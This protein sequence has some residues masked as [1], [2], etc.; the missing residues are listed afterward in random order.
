MKKYN[1][2]WVFGDSWG[3]G[4]E[5]KF[6]QGEVPFANLL[7]RIYD[8]QL[9]NWAI[10]NQSL[11][12]ITRSVAQHAE[13]FE[14]DDLVL[15]V[16]PPD[17][18]WYTEWQTI[19][20]SKQEFFLDKSPE[21]FQYHHQLFIFAIC[22]ILEKKQCQ[23]LLMHNYGDFPLKD[24][25]YIFSKYHQDKFLSTKSL[26]E[27]LTNSP[28]N[29]LDPI[30]VEIQQGNR[31]YTGPYFEGCRYHPNQAGHQMI[32]NIIVERLNNEST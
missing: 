26:T 27:L 23:Y 19:Q 14:K 3:F 21:W 22:E 30:Q 8:C 28:K 25:N 31:I 12:L 24:Y 11:G 5:L 2:I 9:S 4:S 13:S 32:A 20:Y 7:A 16:I 29:K 1:Q 6:A 17:S 15:I 18:R 10:E